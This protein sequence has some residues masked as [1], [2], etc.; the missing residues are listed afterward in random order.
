MK[1]ILVVG[2]SRGIGK[3]IVERLDANIHV[4]SRNEIN[5][6][7]EGVNYIVA[8][9]CDENIELNFDALDSVIYCPGTINLKPFT[10]LKRADFDHDM[11]VNFFGAV[12]VIQKSIKLLKKSENASV[13][14][15]STVAAKIGMPFHASIASAKSAIEGLTK[16]LAAEYAPKIRFN[17]IAPSLTDTSLASKLL[18]NEKVKENSI[19]TNPMKMIGDPND[20][21]SMVEWLISDE[22]KWFTGQIIN[23]DGG[24]SS[25][26]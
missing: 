10:S 13:V 9:A 3:A 26:K 21:A 1:N 4:I 8:D 17:C 16:S 14:L 5:D 23:F 7:K 12:N 2:G 19:N 15:F 24:M 11:E 6:K 18:S 25:I 20:I 22:A